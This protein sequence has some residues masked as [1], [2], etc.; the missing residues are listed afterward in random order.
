M[1]ALVTV[2]AMWMLQQARV[3]QN[4]SVS[5]QDAGRQLRHQAYALAGVGA[6]VGIVVTGLVVIAGRTVTHRADRARTTALTVAQQQLPELVVRLQHGQDVDTGGLPEPTG[7]RDEFGMISDA[8]A[9]LARHALDSAYAVHKERDGFN[10]FS[11]GVAERALVAVAALLRKLDELQRSPDQGPEFRDALSTLDHETVQLRRQLENLLLLVGGTVPHPHTRPVTAG[12]IVI[13][14][15]GESPGLRRVHTEFGAEG[16]LVPEAAGALTHLLAELIDNALAYSAPQLE[17]VTRSVR[18]AS[19]IAFEVEDRGN[20]LSA[21]LLSEMNG[22]LRVAPL[23]A[24]IADTDQLGLFVVGRL[25]AQLNVAVTL[26]P[27][28]YGGL[29]AVVMVPRELLVDAPQAPTE[30]TSPAVPAPPSYDPPV[31]GPPTRPI[32]PF[33]ASQRPSAP[34]LTADG[35]P[36]RTPGAQ[37]AEQLRDS[38]SD[39][40]A[41]EASRGIDQRTPEQIAAQ[42][43]GFPTHTDPDEETSP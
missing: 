19:G 12:N 14:A 4:D 2:C 16:W 5:G 15:V 24:E 37:L 7:H 36:R 28:A 6:V 35:L 31:P 13:D 1:T 22:R 40:H 18:T 41:A 3:L 23:F 26:R 29:S 39:V 38:T 25:A 30:P 43:A 21:D 42:F 11:A 20:G 33:P 9:R 32:A 34:S 10:R 17:V 27:S 8:V